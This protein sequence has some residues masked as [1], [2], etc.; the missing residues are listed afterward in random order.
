[1]RKNAY[2]YMKQY[3]NRH[4]KKYNAFKR[5]YSKKY[6]ERK[7]FT[8]KVYDLVEQGKVIRGTSCYFCGSDKM[9]QACSLSPDVFDSLFF[10]Y[11]CNR[12]FHKIF[13]RKYYK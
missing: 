9:I 4:R 5:R 3:K 10:C 12:N 11:R 13:R 6:P 7:H 2:Y 8:N 1:M